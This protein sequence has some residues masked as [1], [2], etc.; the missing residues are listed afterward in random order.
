MFSRNFE[1]AEH[2]KSVTTTS[3]IEHNRRGSMSDGD[4]QQ[5]ILDNGQQPGQADIVVSRQV[6]VAYD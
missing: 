5:D 2:G 6:V 1:L 3:A 4:S